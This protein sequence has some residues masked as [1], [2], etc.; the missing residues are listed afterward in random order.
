MLQC[1]P[2]ALVRA[3]LD[4]VYVVRRNIVFLQQG[5]QTTGARMCQR[6]V[7]MRF[8]PDAGMVEYPGISEPA[9]NLSLVECTGGS[10]KI[11]GG[12]IKRVLRR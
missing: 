1:F 9:D 3:D 2:D 7:G 4:A 12:T 11:P 6:T 10:R 5:Q 8:D